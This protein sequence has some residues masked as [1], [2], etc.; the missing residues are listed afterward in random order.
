METEQLIEI[1]LANH[2]STQPLSVL[3]IGTGSGCIAISLKNERPNWTIH[4]LDISDPALRIARKNAKQHDAEVQ[5]V[6]A[7][8]KQDLST[9]FE[10]SSFDLIISNPPY[11]LP[12]EKE[13]LEKQ[14]KD[15]EP[16]K[17]LFCRSINEEYQ[18]IINFS[19]E[20]LMDDGGLYLELNADHSNSVL[21]LFENRIWAPSLLKDYDEKP[22]FIQASLRE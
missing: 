10:P 12:E 17:A 16:S 7:D 14:V 20:F 22:R 5:F 2:P 3:D 8:I 1:V 15:F 9:V 13:T 4:A 6:E 21:S 11:V 19:Q 18:T